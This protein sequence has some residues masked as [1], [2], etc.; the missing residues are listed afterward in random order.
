MT[1]Q[2]YHHNSNFY[3]VVDR[4]SSFVYVVDLRNYNSRLISVEE[5]SSYEELD[6]SYENVRKVVS[7]VAKNIDICLDDFDKFKYN[8]IV[9]VGANSYYVNDWRDF[10]NVIRV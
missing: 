10:S 7:N 5:L 1:F 8:K 9:H 6:F 3:L 2:L 4:A